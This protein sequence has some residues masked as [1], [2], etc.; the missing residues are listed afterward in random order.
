MPLILLSRSKR[1]YTERDGKV[2]IGGSISRGGSEKFL[3]LIMLRIFVRFGREESW[4]GATVC[5]LI[6]R[7]GEKNVFFR[8]F[9]GT[10][11]DTEK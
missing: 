11:Q 9:S 10:K 4:C 1:N 7:M 2:F 3:S 5:V 6:L 8:I